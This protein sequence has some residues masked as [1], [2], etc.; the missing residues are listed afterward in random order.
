MKR[1]APHALF[2]IQNKQNSGNTRHVY[3]PVCVA[4]VEQLP[5]LHCSF[6]ANRNA[7]TML[8]NATRDDARVLQTS[9]RY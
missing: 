9:I 6:S 3:R 1:A 4:I 5:Q 7:C 2:Q 8:S